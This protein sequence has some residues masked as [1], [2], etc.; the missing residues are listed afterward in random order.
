MLHSNSYLHHYEKYGLM[1]NDIIE[2][3]TVFENIITNYQ[4]L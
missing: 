3:L 4:E 1:K 2:Y